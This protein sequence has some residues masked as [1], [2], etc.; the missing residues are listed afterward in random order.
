M[1]RWTS[2][3]HKWTHLSCQAFVPLTLAGCADL[4]A[5]Y[6]PNMA[7][8]RRAEQSSIDSA[9]WMNRNSCDFQPDVAQSCVLDTGAS[10][11]PAVLA[12]KA[13]ECLIVMWTAVCTRLLPEHHTLWCP[14]ASVHEC[15]A[16]R[17]TVAGNS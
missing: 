8:D 3:C 11:S 4:L 10:G 7:V 15:K 17:V 14:H 13:A 9:P 16:H 1:Q 5:V 2:A 12:A 6:S